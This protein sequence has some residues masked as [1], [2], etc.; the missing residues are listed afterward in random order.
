MLAIN[1]KWSFDTVAGGDSG[2]RGALFPLLLTDVFYPYFSSL[3]LSFTVPYILFSVKATMPLFAVLSARIV[4]KERQS[5]RVY[6][7]LIP[8]ITGVTIA[9]F[10]EMSFDLNGLL[11]ALLSTG[12]YAVLNVFVKK[13][14][15]F[16]SF[17]SRAC[18]KLRMRNAVFNFWF[19]NC[20]E[21][22]KVD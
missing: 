2:G 13:V 17:L 3:T 4:L 8:I 11:S 16:V 6:L 14:L 10:T 7:S 20:P 15:C 12:V 21:L 5:R 22:L 9:T 18:W 19:V 1:D